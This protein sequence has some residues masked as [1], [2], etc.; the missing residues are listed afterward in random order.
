MQHSKLTRYRWL[1]S[2]LLP[3]AIAWAVG[4]AYNHAMPEPE[5]RWIASLF[6]QKQ[7]IISGSQC[8]KRILILGGSG[9]H[10]GIDARQIE[11]R[12]GLPTLNLGLH[13]GL[14]I[15]AIL[16]S[17][18][19][20]IQA[21]DLVIL[22]PEYAT[23]S[24]KDGIGAYA[25]LFGAAVKRPWIGGAD[26]IQQITE[27]FS[28]G[29]PGLRAIAQSIA[30]VS[31]TGYSDQVSSQ[32][33]AIALPKGASNQPGQPLLETPTPSSHSLAALAKF[34]QQLAQKGAT[35]VISLPW[36]LSQ[37]DEQSIAIAQ[38]YVHD[39]SAI[40]PVLN[41]PISYNLQSDATLFSDTVYH[42]SHKGIRQ[43][44]D[45]LI[46]QLEDRKR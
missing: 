14:G 28:A 11:E 41:N 7:A 30:G 35:L 20:E 2:W 46:Q 33:D 1:A 12:T 37:R 16:A 22:I 19:N 31:P 23:L 44:S 39:L 42:L 26:P 5:I 21:G 18:E 38:R 6:Q 24:S 27:T 13:A 3:V 4:C 29:R 45:E 36:I 8:A 43:R 10:F 17:F 15:N 34:Q 40:A 32:G 25:A 9:T